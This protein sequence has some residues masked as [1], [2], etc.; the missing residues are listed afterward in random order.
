MPLSVAP[1]VV[2]PESAQLPN[3]SRRFWG[4][5]TNAINSKQYGQA[6]K[7]KQEIEERQREKAAARKAKDEEWTP[8]FFTGTVTP[9]GKP[10]LSDE[11]INA[12]KGLHDGNFALEENKELG[13]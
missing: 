11:G 13:A 1:K 12:L 7:L 9:L 6:T 10:D 4:D 8:R 2:P 5:V 3:E